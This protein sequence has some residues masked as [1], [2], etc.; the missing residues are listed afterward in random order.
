MSENLENTILANLLRNDDY[1]RTVI[2]FIRKSYFTSDTRETFD[3][4]LKYVQKYSSLPTKNALKIELEDAGIDTS[5]IADIYDVEVKSDTDWIVEKTEKWCQDRAIEIA[6]AQTFNIIQ[7]KDPK[8]T[9]GSIPQMLQDAL[10]VTFDSSVGHDYFGDA[11]E[12]FKKLREKADKL[13]FDIGESE[14]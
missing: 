14:A 3:V 9:K 12:R 11:E 13:P 1:M 7:G 2:P 6:I 8:R 4:I 10:A 5:S